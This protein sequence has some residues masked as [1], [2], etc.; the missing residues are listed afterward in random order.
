MANWAL[1]RLIENDV[2]RDPDAEKMPAMPKVY[3]YGLAK[4]DYPRW[5]TLPA[6][7]SLAVLRR[8]EQ[9][10]RSDRY[11][12]LWTSE[13]ARRVYQ[14]AQPFSTGDFKINTVT[15]ENEQRIAVQAKIGPSRQTL[16]LSR[17]KGF[18]RQRQALQNVIHGP[19]G[20]DA[21]TE[22]TLYRR[23]ANTGDHRE[24]ASGE[25]Q[26]R[27]RI[28]AK[29]CVLVP[30]SKRK[31]ASGTLI[32]K[33]HKDSLIEALDTKGERIWWYHGDHARQIVSKHEAHLS[34]LQRLADDRKHEKRK[35]KRRGEGFREM[36]R[37]VSR[38]DTRRIQQIA[39]EVAA[40][41][42][43]FA[44]RRKYA[45]IEY[46]DS[47]RSFAHN[48]RWHMLREKIKSK[49]RMSGLEFIER[50]GDETDAASAR[51]TKNKE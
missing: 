35:P 31:M 43:A 49:S 4:D 39:D 40:S 38:K 25:D 17:E 44:F 23:K 11:Q 41:V 27:W 18:R 45:E 24:S 7:A 9:D 33:T 42:V 13:R 3:L 51:K 32:V 6:A 36:L 14:Y 30:R 2:R 8:V 22:L 5:G 46:D 26:T 29:I 28:F 50:S 16:I 10:W 19:L 48:F 34:R 12:V 21:C 47:E 37:S 15:H 1:D 20:K